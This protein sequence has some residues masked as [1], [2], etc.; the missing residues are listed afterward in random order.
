[1]GENASQIEREITAERAEL[2]RN[3]DALETKARDL[4]DWRVHYRNH[5]GVFLGAAVGVGLALG[6]LSHRSSNSFGYVSYAH[7]PERPEPRRPLSERLRGPKA[8]RLVDTWGYMTDALLAVAT[9]KAVDVISDY[10][11][12]FSD[13]YRR[14]ADDSGPSSRTFWPETSTPG[15]RPGAE[16][17]ASRATWDAG[18]SER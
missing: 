14:R 3:L 12:G 15:G 13:A 11:P 8:R 18:R 4:A 9:A 2:G 7:P 5:A 6:A 1:M 16:A 10:L 17:N